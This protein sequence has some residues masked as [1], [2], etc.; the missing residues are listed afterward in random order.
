LSRAATVTGGPGSLLGERYAGYAYAYPHKSAYRVLDPPVPL[1]EAWQGEPREALFL[2]LHVPFCEMR[3]GFCNLFTQAVPAAQRVEEYRRAVARQ[4]AQVAAAVGPAKVAR[5]AVGGGTPTYL[6]AAALGEL[7]DSVAGAFGA[8]LVEA[9]VSVETSPATCS[10]AH[11]EVL[12]TRG[13]DRVSMGVQTL[14][15]AERRA[16]ARP[17]EAEVVEAAM[18]RLAAAGFPTV[19][20]DLIY[21]IPGQTTESWRHTL[22]GVLAHEPDEVY[23]YPL[24]V[25]ERTGLGRRLEGGPPETR[26]ELYE[27]GRSRLLEAGYRQISMRFFR[28]GPGDGGGPT[29]CC[30]EDGMVGVGPGARSYTRALHYS[31][32]YAVSQKGVKGLVE[33]WVSRPDAAFAVADHGVHLDPHEERRRYL[34]KSLLRVDG[35]DRAGYRERFGADPLTE[36]P[37]LDRLLAAELL[38]EAPGLL[39]PTPL[40]LAWSDALGPWL[41]SDEVRARSAGFE[42]R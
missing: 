21:G 11:L 8:S 29:Y 30:Q 22:D 38:R 17:E 4:A 6:E 5:V 13:V 34:I 10:E 20:L 41:Y 3:C 31:S 15:A 33:E 28:R 24:Y 23:L 39:E 35:L 42:L 25:R 37:E 12:R 7:L 9:G 36:F 1:A 2:Y 40:G 19:N 32:E 26:P 16:L 18:A 14:V 27:L